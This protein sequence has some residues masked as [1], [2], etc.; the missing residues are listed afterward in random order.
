MAPPFLKETKMDVLNTN[1]EVWVAL[2]PL[3]EK[4]YE[5]YRKNL[6]TQ[7]SLEIPIHQD[8]GWYRFQMHELMHIFGPHLIVG[9]DNV[10]ENNTIFLSHP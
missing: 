10:F 8:G 5:N 1:D 6:A 3:G 7:L 2:T 4:V 9:A